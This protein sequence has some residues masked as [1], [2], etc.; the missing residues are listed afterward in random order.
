MVVYY[1]QYSFHTF[2]NVVS[3]PNISSMSFRKYSHTTILLLYISLNVVHSVFYSFEIVQIAF[4]QSSK[5]ISNSSLHIFFSMQ[6]V[7][8]ELLE[9]CVDGLWKAERYEVI[10]EI[11]KLIIPIYEKR[12]EFEVSN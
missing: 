5:S 11:S 12:R 9:H 6:E 3:I 10:S 2:K 8:L 7:L 4:A 1:C